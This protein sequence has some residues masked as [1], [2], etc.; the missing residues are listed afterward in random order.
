M[1]HEL[2]PCIWFDGNAE[3]AARFYCSI[4]KDS[5]MKQCTPMVVTFEVCGKQVMGLNGGPMFK[6]NPSISFFV[7]CSSIEE[8]N[9]VWNKLIDG[10]SALIEIGKQPWSELYG[11]VKDKFGVTWQIMIAYEKG[12]KQPMCPSLLF[13]NDKFGKAEEAVNLYT[14]VF[15]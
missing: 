11:W 3:E 10:G 7:Q 12:G 14:S 13:V 2:Y 8:T 5:S 4:F 1:T 15:D 6:V 9:E